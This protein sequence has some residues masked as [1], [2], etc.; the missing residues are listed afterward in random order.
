MM[1]WEGLGGGVEGYSLAFVP[2]SSFL[3]SL[4]HL[5]KFLCG[6]GGW[7]CKLIS[8]FSISLDQAEQNLGT[9]IALHDKSNSSL[10]FG[11]LRT[12]F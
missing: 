8:M 6:G 9:C 4:E 3:Q 7:W 11:T 1:Q 10:K 12:Q 5:E 2:N